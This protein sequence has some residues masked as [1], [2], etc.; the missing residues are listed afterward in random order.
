MERFLVIGF[1]AGC[2]RMKLAERAHIR[3]STRLQQHNTIKTR[4]SSIQLNQRN[5]NSANK[6]A[7]NTGC[8]LHCP[9]V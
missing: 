8:T 7:G 9:N 6:L 4:P 2:L 5:G 3:I 1:I